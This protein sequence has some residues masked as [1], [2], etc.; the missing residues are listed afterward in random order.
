MIIEGAKSWELFDNALWAITNAIIGDEKL[1]YFILNDSD[2]IFFVQRFLTKT[3]CEQGVI[4]KKYLENIIWFF[5]S[6]IVSEHLDMH[7]NT[8]K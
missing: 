7:T 3:D 8:N 5:Y 6:L 2:L 4:N 1:R